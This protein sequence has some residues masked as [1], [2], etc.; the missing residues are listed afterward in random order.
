MTEVNSDHDS[1][2][3]R[4]DANVVKSVSPDDNY[5]VSI[6]VTII[7]VKLNNASEIDRI[8]ANDGINV[9]MARVYAV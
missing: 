2:R 5:M 8:H 9:F 6:S 4:H 3:R 7:I 1:R